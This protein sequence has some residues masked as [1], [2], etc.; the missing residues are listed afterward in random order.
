MVLFLTKLASLQG[1][2]L[3]LEMHFVPT[4]MELSGA[5]MSWE[6]PAD[7]PVVSL[8]PADLLFLFLGQKQLG[9]T[10]VPARHWQA[11]A[12]ETLCEMPT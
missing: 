10:L 6:P 1:L 5:K 3:L 8:S 11:G 2:R 9:E 4:G 12:P 7:S